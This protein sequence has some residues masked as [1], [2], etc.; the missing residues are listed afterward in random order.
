M[1][2]VTLNMISTEN[3]YGTFKSALNKQQSMFANV[4][5]D[6]EAA[7]KTSC[8]SAQLFAKTF[9]C[10]SESEFVRQCLVYTAKIVYPDKVQAFKNISLLWN[11]C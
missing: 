8:V 7:A 2:P 5:K 10:F 11:T 1:K 3:N 9:K 6:N 4:Q